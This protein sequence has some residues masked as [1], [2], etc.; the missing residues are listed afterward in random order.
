M[1][2]SR[3]SYIFLTVNFRVEG[4][5]RNLDRTLG[6][7]TSSSPEPDYPP[8][9]GLYFLFKNYYDILFQLLF[10]VNLNITSVFKE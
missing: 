10:Y 4:A 2:Y 7:R 1:L 5:K 3:E 8:T 9:V 6:K